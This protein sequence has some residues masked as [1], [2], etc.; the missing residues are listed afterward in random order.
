VRYRVTVE[1]V[2]DCP[3]ELGTWNEPKNVAWNVEQSE[4]ATVVSCE[5]LPE[6]MT[7]EAFVERVRARV[8]DRRREETAL[9][10]FLRALL[11]EHDRGR[12]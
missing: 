3:W 6:P 11:T 8:S 10:A 2:T 1:V 4:S 7:P 12:P 5:P 9:E